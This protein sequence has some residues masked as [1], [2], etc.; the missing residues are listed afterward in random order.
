MWCPARGKFSSL[1]LEVMSPTPS[2]NLK[3][4]REAAL[5][6]QRPWHRL[7]KTGNSNQGVCRKLGCGCCRKRGTKGPFVLAH[8]SHKA[9]VAGAKGIVS[10]AELLLAH[11]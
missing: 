1:S 3:R 2:S 7:Q 6:T 4:K 11:L 10:H 5:G 8:R 9:S